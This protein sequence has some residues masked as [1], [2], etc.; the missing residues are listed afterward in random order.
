MLEY[1]LTGEYPLRLQGVMAHDSG[2]RA[3]RKLANFYE[4]EYES[5]G[6]PRLFKQVYV[7]GTL[8]TVPVLLNDSQ[9]LTTPPARNEV[10]V[11]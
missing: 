4:L 1:K 2:R 5:D 3:F 7:N 11:F 10:L 8:K 6:T 9:V